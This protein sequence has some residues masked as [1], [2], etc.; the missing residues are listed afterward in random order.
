[1]HPRVLGRARP[2]V[3]A[4][5]LTMGAD[6]EVFIINNLS[7]HFRCTRDTVLI[8]VGGI[9]AQGGKVSS[10]AIVRFEA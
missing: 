3:A 5:E 2:V 7:G 1:M 9:I 10:D 8:A 6:G 4:G